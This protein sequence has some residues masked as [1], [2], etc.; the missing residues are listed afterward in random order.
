ML[1]YKDKA[2]KM[3]ATSNIQQF[4][5]TINQSTTSARALVFICNSWSIST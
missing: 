3:T 1:I 4:T 2:G 5:Y